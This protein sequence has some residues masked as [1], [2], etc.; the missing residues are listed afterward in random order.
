MK[1]TSVLLIFITIAGNEVLKPSLLHLL[2]DSAIVP[3]ILTKDFYLVKYGILSKT[4]NHNCYSDLCWLPAET[5]VKNIISSC[6]RARS[7]Q[8]SITIGTEKHRQNKLL[9]L[10]RHFGL[11]HSMTAFRVDGDSA[12]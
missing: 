6:N 2:S 5:S 4:F 8:I 10:S 9:I 7:C 1:T 3:I 11:D 12:W